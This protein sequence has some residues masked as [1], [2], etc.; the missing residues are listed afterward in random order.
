MEGW[1]KTRYLLD[2]PVAAVRLATLSDDMKKV[3]QMKLALGK[4]Q[5]EARAAVAEKDKYAKEIAHI[6]KISS[7]VVSLDETNRS[8]QTQVDSLKKELEA[9]KAEHYSRAKSA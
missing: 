7:N 6:K 2:Q 3:D 4:A 9:T 8:L 5:R 1:V